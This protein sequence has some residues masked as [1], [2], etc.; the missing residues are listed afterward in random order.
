MARAPRPLLLLLLLLLLLQTP[1]PGGA[2]SGR[3]L[4]CR[5]LQ[6][7]RGIHSRHIQSVDVAPPGPHC[8]RAEVLATLKDGRR[9][10][11]DPQAPLVKRILQK[12]LSQGS[13]R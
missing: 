4:R 12:L 8:A 7:T 11:L 10:C 1:S 3:E 9:A 2:P 6:T 5:C 13:A